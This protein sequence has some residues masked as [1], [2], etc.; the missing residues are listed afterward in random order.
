MMWKRWTAISL[1][2]LSAALAVFAASCSAPAEKTAAVPAVDPLERGK[3]LVTSGPCNDCHT[4]GTF[5]GAPDFTRTLSGSEMGWVGPWGT[6]FARNLTPDPETGLGNWT[7]EQIATAIRTGNR[8]DGRQL[9]PAMPWQS[10]ANFTQEDAIAI[11]TYLKSLPPI[12]HKVP[13][14]LPPGAKYNGPTLQFP[15]PSEWD[16]R[17]LPKAP[18]AATAK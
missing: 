15:P 12:Q 7:V 1:T 4:P 6:V 8:P 9:A 11:A 2:V 13:D 17:N 16:A 3:Y 10:F 14:V 18:A 5:W